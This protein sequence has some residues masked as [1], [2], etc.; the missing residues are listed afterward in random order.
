MGL[1]RRKYHGEGTFSGNALYLVGRAVLSGPFEGVERLPGGRLFG[2]AA[3]GPA[4][5]PQNP[6]IDGDFHAELRGVGAPRLFHDAV[7]G[8][9]VEPAG[10]GLLQIGLGVEGGTGVLKSAETSPRGHSGQTSFKLSVWR[11]PR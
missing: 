2:R 4:A 9:R 11:V 7:G 1:S 6:P 5:D 3:A 8:Q 10:D